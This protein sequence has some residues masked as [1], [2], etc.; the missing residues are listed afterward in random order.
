M[1][2]IIKKPGE[3]AEVEVMFTKG[4]WLFKI[5]RDVGMPIIVLMSIMNIY[6]NVY[7]HIHIHMYIYM[8][9]AVATK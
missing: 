7:M 8:I 9:K 6:T 1:S 4:S 5:L 2:I 3:A